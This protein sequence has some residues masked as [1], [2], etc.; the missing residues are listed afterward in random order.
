M[1]QLHRELEPRL[2]IPVEPT[3]SLR[4]LRR[5]LVELIESTERFNRG[6]KPFLEA[7]DLA[8]VNE[9]RDGYNRWYVLE[10]ECALRSPRL[11]RLGFQRLEPITPET[12]A[13]LFP[14]LPVVCFMG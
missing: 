11:A 2:R 14:P 7:V 8:R 4:R 13:V 10:K 3:S 5:A 12:L 6:W 9:L 1:R